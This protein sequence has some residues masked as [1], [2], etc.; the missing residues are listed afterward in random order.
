MFILFL[1]KNSLM[2]K[3]MRDATASSFVAKVRGEVFGHF[4][5]VAVKHHS[6]M[7]NWLFAFQDKLFMNNPFDIKE[8]YEHALDFALHLSRL[9]LS[10]WVWAFSIQL[11]LSSPNACLIIARVSVSLFPRFAQICFCSFVESIV[12]S[13]QAGYTTPNKRT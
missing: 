12:K 8:N 13:H 2:R 1:V 9:F 11:M 4:H 10:Q 5:V 6:S 3:E 7:R